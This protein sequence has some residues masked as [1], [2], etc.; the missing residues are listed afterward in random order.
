MSDKKTHKLLM[1]NDNVNS[2]QYIM[3]SLIRFC[4][5]NPL[6]AEQ[7]ALIANNNGKCF[8]KSGDFLEMFDLKNTFDNLDIKTE[9]QE[10]AKSNLY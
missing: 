9:I 6:Q 1:H 5:H 3:A 10:Y 4:K 2:Y 7:C 8:V